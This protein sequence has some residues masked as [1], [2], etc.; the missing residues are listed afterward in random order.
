MPPCAP[1]LP[2]LVG[3][4]Q[5]Q[6]L[7]D[8]GGGEDGV[9]GGQLRARWGLQLHP[10]SLWNESERERENIHEHVGPRH[11]LTKARAFI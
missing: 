3:V 6:D 9:E 7:G 10:H 4:S 8:G 5:Q 2:Y 1:A 11:T